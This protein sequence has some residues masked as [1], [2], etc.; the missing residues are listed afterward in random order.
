M[1]KEMARKP[2]SAKNRALRFASRVVKLSGLLSRASYDFVHPGNPK[3]I[4]LLMPV[5]MTS[6]PLPPSVPCFCFLAH[7]STDNPRLY[8]Y[9]NHV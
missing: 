2:S 5:V 9:M 4:Q 8:A 6:K 3:W 7:A 1:Q